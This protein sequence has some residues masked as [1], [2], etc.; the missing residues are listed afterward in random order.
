MSGFSKEV[1][2]GTLVFI[3]PFSS[4]HCKLEGWLK[5]LSFRL[6]LKKTKDL[7]KEAFPFSAM[8]DKMFGV[9]YKN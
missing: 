3:L 5:T 7:L 1:P 6:F 2:V 8:A 4:K 9:L